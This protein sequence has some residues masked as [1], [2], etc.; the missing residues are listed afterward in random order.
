[1]KKF[2]DRWFVLLILS[3]SSCKTLDSVPKDFV[4][5]PGSDKG[6]VI[7][8]ITY[9]GSYSGYS[10][11]LRKVGS[12]EHQELKIG[13][14]AG[15]LPPGLLDWD[16]N[17]RDGRGNV[18]VVE[19]PV[20]DYEIFSWRVS[21]GPAYIQPEQDFSIPF[22][23][24]PGK[25][26]Y[27]GNFHFLR[28]SGL[29]GTVAAVDVQYGDLSSR[30]LGIL[31]N[32]YR[33]VNLSTIQAA[34]DSRKFGHGL[35]GG[36]ATTFTHTIAGTPV[37]YRNSIFTPAQSPS[38]L[39]FTPGQVFSGELLSVRSPTDS[40]SWKL[41]NASENEISF[42]RSGSARNE[43][44]IALA[45]IFALPATPNQ[46]AFVALIKNSIEAE[47]PPDRFKAL[48]A[49]YQYTDQRGYP[50]VKFNG[51]NQDMQALTANRKLESQK[52]QIYALYCRHPKRP[53]IGIHIGFSH[54]GINIDR[55]LEAKA[56]VF[57]DGVQAQNH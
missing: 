53:E 35:G 50:C 25:A 38:T 44:Y 13:T 16:I 14:G 5:N 10:V 37:I 17:Q 34:Y 11:L 30:D 40:S 27:I 23:I 32:K 9:R 21:S 4:L 56:L 6:V 1:M 18:F 54:R 2:G 45:S 19:L 12:A 52:L 24:T 36:S 15:L 46:E 42:G 47:A 31:Q 57:M 33:G 20:G 41:L 3:L 55:D 29:G 48:E 39:T 8:S 49:N 51:V 28:K 26:S 43:S 22:N 7:S